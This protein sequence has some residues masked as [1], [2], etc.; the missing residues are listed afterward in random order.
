[1]ITN[2][3]LTSLSELSVLLGAVF[4]AFGAIL[5][6]FY[7]YA[8]AREKDFAESRRIE[9]EAFRETIKTLS[10]AVDKQTKSIEKQTKSSE[11]VAKA[12]T[13]SAKEA[14]TR[15]GHLAEISVENKNQIIK[16]I[17]NIKKSDHIATQI[18]DE[19]VIN[20]E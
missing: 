19:Q 15:N 17:N 9:A 7:K 10:I 18:V 11:K 2:F 13:K 14:E 5:V 6:G 1:M 4:G 16:A 3:A 12:T 20:K 8:Q